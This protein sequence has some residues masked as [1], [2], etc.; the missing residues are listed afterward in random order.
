MEQTI[1]III[2][3][4]I[5]I[6]SFIVI[7]SI[8]SLAREGGMRSLGDLFNLSKFLEIVGIKK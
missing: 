8:I 2:L 4:V 1:W 5:A 7:L 6:L 3:I